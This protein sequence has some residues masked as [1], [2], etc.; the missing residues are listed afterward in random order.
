MVIGEEVTRQAA[1]LSGQARSGKVDLASGRGEQS[2]ASASMAER[3]LAGPSAK[4][5]AKF[6]QKQEFRP[7]RTVE[8]NMPVGSKSLEKVP[9]LKDFLAASSGA[10]ADAEYVVGSYSCFAR[11]RMTVGVLK[12]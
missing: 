8:K 5:R 10:E 1:L 11:S 9:M 7:T 6:A 4:L 2:S 12:K 3:L